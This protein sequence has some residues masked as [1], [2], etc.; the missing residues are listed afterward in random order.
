MAGMTEYEASENEN[1]ATMERIMAG[2]GL[3]EGKHCFYS[4]RKHRVGMQTSKDGGRERNTPREAGQKV[5]AIPE[6]QKHPNTN[7]Q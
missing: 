2:S 1:G 5:T 6:N 3:W 4:G 7:K